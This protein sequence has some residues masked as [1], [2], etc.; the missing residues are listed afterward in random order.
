MEAQ[1][2]KIKEDELYHYGVKGM[3]WRKRKR[4][5]RYSMYNVTNR[6]DRYVR[7]ED[8]NNKGEYV[9]HTYPKKLNRSTKNEKISKTTRG[10]ANHTIETMKPKSTMRARKN[11]SR[12]LSGFG[13]TSV[14]K[15]QKAISKGISWFKKSSK[16]KS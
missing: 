8:F 5:I 12:I 6:I 2:I 1:Y 4:P 16:R 15:A 9:V 14:S 11:V 3:K 7:L 13:K 10:L